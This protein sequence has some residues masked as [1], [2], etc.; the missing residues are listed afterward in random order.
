MVRKSGDTTP[1]LTGSATDEGSGTQANTSLTLNTIYDAKVIS[2]EGNDRYHVLVNT[3]RTDVNSVALALPFFGGILGFRMRIRL[4][5]GA[6]VKIV[7]AKEPFIFSGAPEDLF[8]D[9]NSGPARAVFGAS[10]DEGV[11]D[12]SAV[13]DDML[14]GE[15]EIGGS[16]G[17]AMRFLG[18]MMQMSS[19][20]RAI[21]ETHLTNHMVRIIAQQYQTVTGIGDE[22]I[23]DAG[24][25]TLERSWS[26]YRHE[27]FG[28]L[29]EARALFELDG[30]GAD[31]EKLTTERVNLQGRYRLLEYIGFAGDFMHS[32]LAD[33][34]TTL[35]DL[36]TPGSG[37]RAGK[38]WIHR[39]SDGSLIFHSVADIM[40]EHTTRIPVPYRK[41][42]HEDQEITNNRRYRE[43]SKEALKLWDWKTDDDASRY[44]TAYQLRSYSRWLS[45]YHAF[46]RMI[47]L[48]SEYDLAAESDEAYEPSYTN[49]E[50]D[51]ERASSQEYLETYSCICILRD[52]SI[53][54]H[55][56]YGSAVVMSGGNLQLSA[57]K[58][59]DLEAAGDV[60]IVAGRSMF[61]KARLHMEM[62]AILGGVT[63]YGYTVVKALCQAGPIWL[64][65]EATTTNIGPK[66]EGSPEPE[67]GQAAVYIEAPQGETMI[68]SDGRQ[69]FAIEGTQ[70]DG[71][72]GDSTGDFVFKTRGNFRTSLRGHMLVSALKDVVIASRSTVLR[73]ERLLHQFTTSQLAQGV[74]VKARQLFTE[75][76]VSEQ[77][78]SNGVIKA[79]QMGYTPASPVTSVPGHSNH[80][81]LLDDDDKIAWDRTLTDEETVASLDFSA[82]DIRQAATAYDIRTRGLQ[83]SFLA[84][85]EYAGK[86]E[87]GS[88]QVQTVT[89]RYLTEDADQ[90][91]LES[92]SWADDKATL[93][94]R[95]GQYLGV[96]GSA[97]RKGRH[98]G[99]SNLHT[100]S[101]NAPSAHTIDQ[102]WTTEAVTFKFLK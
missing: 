52:G 49:Q 47:Q 22:L 71:T 40:I 90:D 37:R 14:E 91:P 78:V 60:R 1:P 70:G 72:R 53:V 92:W 13:P 30:D 74:V 96:Y 8:P 59:L 54:V 73:G 50:A 58:N 25:P 56:G 43:L 84:P 36:A 2:Y 45:R 38:S 5:E 9:H 102:S 28:A 17:N 65:S 79:P 61:M 98:D 35:V 19:G 63:M 11:K 34:P 4:P 51:R 44:R 69:S 89:Q 94:L 86:G 39:N 99:G 83:W 18:G 21:V 24:R 101:A 85:E 48:D 64:R 88:E 68:R 46:A 95:V 26:S 29:D 16:M 41:A 7:Y 97:V 62:S 6:L 31:Q 81:L 20:D 15:I 76:L 80:I 57:A 66:E 32:F 93:T 82:S 67:H 12:A 75:K 77:I 3:P 87:G 27:V 23:F 42:H 10:V 100:P 33:P 55:D